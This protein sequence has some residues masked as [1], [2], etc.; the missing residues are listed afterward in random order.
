M[1]PI[2]FL[3]RYNVYLTPP[4]PGVLSNFYSFAQ[5]RPHPT[6]LFTERWPPGQGTIYCTTC[7]KRKARVMLYF[8]R[9]YILVKASVSVVAS[10][11]NTWFNKSKL[12]AKSNV[13]VIAYFFV[14]SYIFF[15]CTP[16]KCPFI[17]NVEL[18]W[19]K[20]LFNFFFRS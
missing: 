5:F 4:P 8:Y 18:S 20:F 14:K 3:V 2:F 19:S 10:L 7:P 12:K 15:L 1:T 11:L 6:A 13:K 16:I 17:T 9:S